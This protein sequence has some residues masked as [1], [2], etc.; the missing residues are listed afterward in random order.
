MRPEFHICLSSL[1]KAVCNDPELLVAIQDYDTRTHVAH[2]CILAQRQHDCRLQA[3]LVCC[4]WLV[5]MACRWLVEIGLSTNSAPLLPPMHACILL[6][7]VTFPLHIT[8]NFWFVCL[9]A[10]MCVCLL[11]CLFACQVQA[12][13]THAPPHSLPSELVGL[14]QCHITETPTPLYMEALNPKSRPS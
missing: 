11:G 12:L 2:F 10:Y 6:P 9:L 4:M 5:E 7:I 1:C 3:Q 13:R 14:E 8:N